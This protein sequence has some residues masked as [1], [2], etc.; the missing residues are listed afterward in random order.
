M[1]RRIYLYPDS[2]EQCMKALKDETLCQRHSGDPIDAL[3]RVERDI[4]L[5]TSL[6]S[7][8]VKSRN[9]LESL[10]YEQTL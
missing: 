3:K 9:M 2:I 8:R 6:G 7:D 10:S 1:K 5:K 4:R